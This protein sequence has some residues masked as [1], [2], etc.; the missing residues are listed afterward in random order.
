M[1]ADL[2]IYR[3]IETHRYQSFLLYLG[4]RDKKCGKPPPSFLFLFCLVTALVAQDTTLKKA[5]WKRTPQALLK[6]AVFER[7]EMK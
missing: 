2:L 6:R 7:P 4:A 1:G 5:T 3:S